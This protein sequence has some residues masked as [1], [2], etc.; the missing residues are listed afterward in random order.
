MLTDVKTR[1]GL[2]LHGVC[3]VW[4]QLIPASL[5]LILASNPL[6]TSQ[7]VSR[8]L[9]NSLYQGVPSTKTVHALIKLPIRNM[10]NSQAVIFGKICK[11]MVFGSHGNE[12]SATR[13]SSLTLTLTSRSPREEPLR[14]EL[15]KL[16]RM[17]KRKGVPPSNSMAFQCSKVPIQP[18]QIPAV[19][20]LIRP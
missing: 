6:F 8:H 5:Y 19:L 4:P 10:V 20:E 1:T 15:T 2:Y 7:I 14:V 12:A 16:C 18:S 13:L 3:K 11:H 9:C 17:P